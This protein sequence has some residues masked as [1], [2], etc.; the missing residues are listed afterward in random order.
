[1]KVTQGNEPGAMVVPMLEP[2]V[3]SR[4]R[5]LRQLGWGARR[6]AEEVGVARNSV[7]R[8]VREGT[9]AERQVRPGART[10]DASQEATARELLD[11]PA[12]G[13]AVVVRRLL[14]EQEVE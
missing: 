11:G 14:A 8:Y 5:L 6:I 3:V 4:I 9:S 1:M 12:A 10:L 2:E 13:N 7:R